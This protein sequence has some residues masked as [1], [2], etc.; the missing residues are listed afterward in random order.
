MI[1]WGLAVVVLILA[2]IAWARSKPTAKPEPRVVAAV[3]TSATVR[4]QPAKAK[5]IE[6]AMAQAVTDAMASGIRLEDSAAIKAAMMAA[7]ARV[8][9]G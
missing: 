5:A 9:E 6:A 1:W 4:H 3:M 7:R 2:L 8:L